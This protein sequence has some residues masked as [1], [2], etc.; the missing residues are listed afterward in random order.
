MR[1]KFLRNELIDGTVT[2]EEAEFHLVDDFFTKIFWRREVRIKGFALT[3]EEKKTEAKEER[4]AYIKFLRY[5]LGTFEGL[6]YKIECVKDY[7]HLKIKHKIAC[8]SKI[9]HHYLWSNVTEVKCINKNKE[10]IKGVINIK[11]KF[12]LFIILGF[13]F[14]C[15]KFFYL[16]LIIF[17][18]RN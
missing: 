10:F 9:L 2:L 1:N 13:Q 8:L 6:L 4:T 12:I 3:P 16:L 11:G 17:F 7:S 5:T 14:I 15:A 18:N